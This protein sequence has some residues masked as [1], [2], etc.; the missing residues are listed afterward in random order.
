[1]VGPWPASFCLCLR[2]LNALRRI[3]RDHANGNGELAHRAERLERAARSVRLQGLQHL[4]NKVRRHGADW[5]CAG[6][7]AEVLQD[8]AATDLRARRKLAECCGQ[9]VGRDRRG[10]AA[11]LAPANAD[12]SLSERLV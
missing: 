9:E 11:G 10:N 4:G 12:W 7:I 1:C 5:L 6:F 2:P 3:G 8:T